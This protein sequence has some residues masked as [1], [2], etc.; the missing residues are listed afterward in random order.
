MQSW[1]HVTACICNN[2]CRLSW[3]CVYVLLRQIPVAHSDVL[4]SIFWSTSFF[5]S[6]WNGNFPSISFWWSIIN[7][8]YDLHHELLKII[9]CQ[10]CKS[11]NYDWEKPYVWL[12]CS[13]K[14]LRY[15]YWLWLMFYEMGWLWTEDN[16]ADAFTGALPDD[17]VPNYMCTS[18]IESSVQKLIARGFL[19]PRRDSAWGDFWKSVGFMQVVMQTDTWC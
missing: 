15:W 17:M 2:Y 6:V 7:T 12:K 3:S 18:F 8:C 4:R 10:N 11:I 16:I 9:V 19:R 5:R 1:W 14:G 13:K